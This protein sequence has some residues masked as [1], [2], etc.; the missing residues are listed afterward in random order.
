MTW[1]ATMYQAQ[2]QTLSLIIEPHRGL[3]GRIVSISASGE[4]EAQMTYM[5]FTDSEL[6]DLVLNMVLPGG[7]SPGL[8]PVPQGLL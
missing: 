4:M 3:V 2:C 5:P 1:S 8:S 6:V 7:R